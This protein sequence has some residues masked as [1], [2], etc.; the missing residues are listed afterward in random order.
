MHEIV[1]ACPTAVVLGL[2]FEGREEQQ[3]L[4]TKRAK[5]W[6]VKQLFSWLAKR[7]YASGRQVEV[8]LGHFVSVSLASR[9]TLSSPRGRFTLSFK[10]AMM[11]SVRFGLQ[12]DTRKN[13]WP[14]S[15]R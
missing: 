2:D 13:R 9:L 5:V 4:R 11:C 8:L 15:P 3:R 14:V 7:S 1:L 12:R 6:V 10:T